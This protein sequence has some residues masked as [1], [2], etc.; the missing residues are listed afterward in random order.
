MNELNPYV[1]VE[2]NVGDLVQYR[3]TYIPDDVFSHRHKALKGLG[4]V[5]W[6]NATKDVMNL[7]DYEHLHVRVYW[8]KTK[9]T[10]LM[11]AKLVEPV[12]E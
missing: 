3:T 7:F 10:E 12:K 8:T 9:S 5:L 11:F 6:S 1:E 2:Y 4:I